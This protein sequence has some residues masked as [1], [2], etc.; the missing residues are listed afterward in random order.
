VTRL[1][2]WTCLLSIALAVVA[3]P[4]HASRLEVEEAL[5]T[6][7]QGDRLPQSRSAAIDV[8][9]DLDQP[10]SAAQL[11]ALLA[12]SAPWVTQ[13]D[14]AQIASRRMDVALAPAMF[15]G[16]IDSKATRLT[17]DPD[18]FEIL[19]RALQ[20]FPSEVVAE[21]FSTAE[22]GSMA[23]HATD[24]LS[25][26]WLNPLDEDFEGVQDPGGWMSAAVDRRTRR[27]VRDLAALGARGLVML[28]SDSGDI[29]FHIV[30][31]AETIILVGRLLA[32]GPDKLQFAEAVCRHRG[33]GGV[34]LS[35][36]VERLRG[37]G[38]PFSSADEKLIAALLDSLPSGL[39][40]PF[41]PD[42]TNPVTG[43]VETPPWSE[44]PLT[45]EGGGPTNRVVALGYLGG[46]LILGIGL[47]G[48]RPTWRTVIFRGGAVLLTPLLFAVLEVGLGLAG[49]Q[50]LG[51][52]RPTFNPT[53][54]PQEHFQERVLEEVPHFV[55]VSG[56]TR[57]ASVPKTKAP[58]ELRVVTLGASS[59][60]GSNYL[61]T[62]AWAAVTG[63]RLQTLFPDRPIRVINL[64]TGGAVSDEVFFHARE[65][66]D[67]LDPDLLIVSLGYNDFTQLSSLS[68]YRAY[69]PRDLQL[70]FELDRWRVVR[71]LSD[72]M[73]RVA[74]PVVPNGAFLDRSEMSEADV[75]AIQ[76]VAE[77]SMQ[78]NLERIIA[79]ARATDVDVLFLM[80]GQNEELCGEGSVVGSRLPKCFP[81]ALRGAMIRAAGRDGVSIVDS[82]LA[83]R[84]HA[85]GGVVGF[86]Y[87]WDR[88]HPSRLG[89]SVL[90]EAVAP[91]AARLLRSR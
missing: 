57:F 41:V 37:V 2:L 3:E 38:R 83:L 76:N 35:A 4:A 55:T 15:R 69:S 84:T 59:V 21:A 58:G 68:A 22:L 5:D 25:F 18:V 60:H 6:L 87:Y 19:L 36:A 32:S 90:G 12:T 54:A 61:G 23:V 43:P 50:P 78:S 1:C 44:S 10:L 74:L 16:F 28:Q 81:P 63:R 14:A 65:A 39:R 7:R 70:R 85:E 82:A 8:L 80:Q 31:E 42:R 67:L 77:R 27:R 40:E 89:H 72:V 20:R 46:V 51:T 88:V 48:L 24:R 17:H 11:S 71:V 52:I 91:E 34:Q 33:F 86:Q 56:K 26:N 29:A 79:T 62:E 49:V 66:V 47:A 45:S 73:P 64:G 13:L 30:E 53:N 75:A 9:A